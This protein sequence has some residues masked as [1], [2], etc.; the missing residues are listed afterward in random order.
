MV[1]GMNEVSWHC[2]TFACMLSWTEH[3]TCSSFIV[4]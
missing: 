4:L 2:S 3:I 1:M